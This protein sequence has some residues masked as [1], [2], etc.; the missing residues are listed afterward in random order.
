MRAVVRL[1]M[2]AGGGRQATVLLCLLAAGLA[3]G[4][5]LASLMPLL[6]VAAGVPGD[7]AIERL[8]LGGLG[9]I[10]LEPDLGVLLLFVVSGLVLKGAL[11]LVAM[12][13]VGYAVAGVATGVRLTLIERLLE[14]RWSYFTH[15]PV[16][17]FANLM[18]LEATRAAD[19]YVSAANAITMAIQTVVYVVLAVLVSWQAALVAGVAGALISWAVSGLVRSARRAG[20]RQSTRMRELVGQLSD[21]LNGIKPLKAM[22]RH[23]RMGQ[24]F[25]DQVADL[26]RALR[27][28]VFARGALR[29]LQEPMGAVLV[30]AAFYVATVSWEVPLTRLIIMAVLMANVLGSIGKLQQYVQAALIGESAYRACRKAIDEAGSMRE[31]QSG[32]ATPTLT[33]GVALR[34]VSFAFGDKPVLDGVTMEIPAGGL[35]VVMGP[36]G[37]GKT[38]IAD[39]VMG[40]LEP[41][42]GAVLVDDRDLAEIGLEAWRGLIGYVPQEL[43]LFHDTVLANVTLRE[44]GVSREDALAALHQAGAADFVAA[45]GHG[46]DTTVGE[47]GMQLS[48]GQRQ[49]I[50]LARALV[51]KPKLLILDEVTS[52]LD[53][54][55]EAEIVRNI[56]ALAGTLT[57]LV[58]THQPAWVGAGDRVY[59]L[60]GGRV[61]ALAG[62]AEALAGAA[63]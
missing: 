45:L 61:S 25:A 37:A 19:A 33:R 1:F 22:A 46:L 36:S 56:R 7:S 50:A 41:D 34:D 35:T 38:T 29:Y 31:T 8:V 32:T 9:A 27:R 20:R 62:G 63:S 3:E 55:T 60:A 59:R 21:V 39:L 47:R 14:A 16:G 30:G 4:V 28:Q 40:L 42:R 24:V 53:P 44:A 2:G 12:N 6:T 49:R 52:A 18:S 26:N 11:M 13:H 43:F 10:G 5:G 23:V 48:G 17:R 51:H 15:Q 54:A 58:I 57:V